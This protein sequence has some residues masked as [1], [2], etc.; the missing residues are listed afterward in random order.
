MRARLLLCALALVGAAGPARAQ[1]T[2]VLPEPRGTAVALS[3]DLN[4][5]GIWDPAEQVG[6]SRLA[7]E[8]ILEG[9]R[10]E[11]AALGASGRLECDRF[12]LRFTLLAPPSTWRAASGLLLAALFRPSLQPE[13]FD[14]ARARLLRTLRFQEGDPA[15][16]IRTAAHEALFGE[17]HRWA[18]G[19]C[20]RPETVDSLTRDQAQAAASQRFTPARAA[21]AI[22]GPLTRDE[23]QALLVRHLGDS[24]LPTL[25]PQPDPP[26]L[27]G[28]RELESPTVTAWVA[29]AFPLPREPD[30]EATRLLAYQVEDAVRPSPDRPHVVDA[31]AEVERFGGGGALVVYVVADPDAARGWAERVQALV[32][33]AAAAPPDSAAFDLLQRRYRGERLLSLA[34]PE[35]LAADAADRLFFDHAYVP[36]PQRV[37][38]LTPARLRSAAAALGPAAVAYLGPTPPA[39]PSLDRVLRRP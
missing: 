14:T 18:R 21:G 31:T 27:P 39:S 10:L 32:D 5:G 20:G 35:A 1:R 17:T 4:A 30:D 2:Q 8:T 28:T 37:D 29:L 15:A 11:L 24:R 34:T 3:V 9:L 26:P 23:G 12:G 25:L 38:A 6:V 7:A 19:A 16:E 33:S 36:P 13:A 22:T